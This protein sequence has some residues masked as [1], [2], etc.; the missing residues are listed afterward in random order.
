[1]NERVDL[2]DDEERVE[3]LHMIDFSRN[4]RSLHE[5]LYQ[6]CSR[7]PVFDGDVISKSA[8]D[9][10]LTIGACA[11]VLVKGEDGFNAATYFGNYLLKVFDWLYG[12]LASPTA[13]GERERG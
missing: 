2:M 11:K 12:S 5:P 6:L 13:S 10:L 7:G 8:R 3:L 4:S 9:A 1:M